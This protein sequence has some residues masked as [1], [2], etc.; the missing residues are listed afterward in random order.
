MFRPVRCV[1][2]SFSVLVCLMVPM[3]HTVAQVQRVENARAIDSAR[4][5]LQSI[6]RQGFSG[7]VLVRRRGVP[8]LLHGYGFAD[9]ARTRRMTPATVFDIGSITK[10]MTGTEILSLVADGELTLHDSIGH[11]LDGVPPDKSGITIEY[12]LRHRSGLPE[13]L[14]KDE[15]YVSREWLVQHALNATLGSPPGA[16]ES[17]SN[18]GYSLLGA[19]IE[20]VTGKPYEDV[21]WT[22]QFGPAGLS[23]TGY[24][25]PEWPMGTLACGLWDGHRYGATRDYFGKTGPSWH[26][27]ANG[28]IHSTVEELARWFDSVLAGKFLPKEYSD[29]FTT[30]IEH[31]SRSGI[32]YLSMGGSNVVFTSEYLNFRE[33]DLVVVLFTSNSTWP[34]EK[35]MP[36]LMGRLKSLSAGRDSGG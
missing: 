7:V 16:E 6:E 21:L 35:V 28:G 15:E 2:I 4:S 14:G 13:S 20:K 30:A 11:F 31:Q 8:I 17:Y 19:I 1:G 36:G 33:A 25:R 23:L 27:M 5:Y 32:R 9:C 34:K 24:T 12:L 26:L 22:R 3:R 10:A 18:V 29:M